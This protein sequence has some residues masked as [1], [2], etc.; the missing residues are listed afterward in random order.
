M[1]RSESINWV[2]KCKKIWTLL[3]IDNVIHLSNGPQRRNV[4][5]CYCGRQLMRNWEGDNIVL[6][7]QF[8]RVTDVQLHQRLDYPE[9]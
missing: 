1:T 8:H 5:H 6:N 2:C 9:I 3:I 4:G 7:K